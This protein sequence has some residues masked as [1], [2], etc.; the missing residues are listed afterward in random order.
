ML[1]TF[2]HHEFEREPFVLIRSVVV[3]LTESRGIISCAAGV[4]DWQIAPRGQAPGAGRSPPE[5]A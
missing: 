2:Y 3:E 5:S 4:R 1:S